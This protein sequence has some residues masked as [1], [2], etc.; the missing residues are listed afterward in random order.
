MTFFHFL[1]GIC[2]W[3][4]LFS[5]IIS[6]STVSKADFKSINRLHFYLLLSLFNLIFIFSIILRQFCSVDIPGIN[7]HY[8]LLTPEL[9]FLIRSVHSIVFTAASM[10]LYITLQTEIG[11]AES[12][13]YQL[14]SVLAMNSYSIKFYWYCW[15]YQLPFLQSW[16]SI[17]HIVDT[18]P[19]HDE[20]CG[21]TVD[22]CIEYV[23]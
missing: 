6:W 16:Y 23:F 19:F 13:H 21:R 9:L 18:F 20:L 11:L 8:F 12:K 2:K 3:I 4:R 5:S 22:T 14:E 1:F 15:I 10:T 7:P 17:D